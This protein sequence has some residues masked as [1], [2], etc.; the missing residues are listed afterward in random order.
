MIVKLITS[1]KICSIYLILKLQNLRIKSFIFI[2]NDNGN[3][4]LKLNFLFLIGKAY[5]SEDIWG[6]QAKRER[7]YKSFPNWWV[8][9]NLN[10]LYRFS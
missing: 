3:A 1:Y 6:R 7:L 8:S 9:L 5:N 2:Y 4:C 10:C